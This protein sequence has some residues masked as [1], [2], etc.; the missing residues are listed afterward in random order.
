MASARICS[1]WNKPPGTVVFSQQFN[2]V[3]AVV[4]LVAVKPFAADAEMQTLWKARGTSNEG[5][6]GVSVTRHGS[7]KSTGR[8]NRRPCGEC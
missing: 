5:R 4:L 6:R 1:T 3:F 8:R 2:V 7:A